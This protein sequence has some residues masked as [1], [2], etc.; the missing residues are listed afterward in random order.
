[1]RLELAGVEVRGRS[2]TES[3]ASTIENASA[4]VVTVITVVPSRALALVSAY[5]ADLSGHTAVTHMRLPPG[6]RATFEQQVLGGLPGTSHPRAC[7]LDHAA[8]L[9]ATVEELLDEP[10][11]VEIPEPALEH[12]SAV[13]DSPPASG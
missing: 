5:V 7:L 10:V 6:R 2:W 4:Y 12:A 11:T 9:R 3:C 8:E 1:M 13:W